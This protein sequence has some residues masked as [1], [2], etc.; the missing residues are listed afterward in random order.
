MSVDQ[1]PKN[2]ALSIFG[3]DVP[4]AALSKYGISLIESSRL[5]ST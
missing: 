2:I 4:K 1:I 5:T 3:N